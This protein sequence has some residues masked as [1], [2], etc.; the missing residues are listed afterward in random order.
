MAEI[1]AVA[2]LLLLLHM[3][4]LLWLQPADVAADDDPHRIFKAF[5][6]IRKICPPERSTALAVATGTIPKPMIKN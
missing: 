2:V 4:L 3:L 1:Y 6:S 5:P